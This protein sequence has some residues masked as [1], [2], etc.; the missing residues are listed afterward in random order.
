[1]GTEG[2]ET[3]ANIIERKE[4][5]RRATG[6]VFVWGIGNAVGAAVLHLV[7]SCPR[8]EVL[9]SLTKTQP[10]PIDVAPDRR[11]IW[12]GGTTMSGAPYRLPAGTRVMGGAVDGR[13]QRPRYALVCAT[14][15]VLEL[16]NLGWLHFADLRNLISGRPVGPSQVTAVVTRWPQPASHIDGSYQVSMRARLVEPYFVRLTDPIVVADVQPD[17]HRLAAVM[18]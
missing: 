16:S 1:M 6:G 8:P 18:T 11:V 7:R 17:A 10:R 15:D 9:F 5:E 13:S 2:G 12:R 14:D 3:L 4:L